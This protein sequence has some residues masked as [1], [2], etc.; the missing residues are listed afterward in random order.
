MRQRII[1][2][3]LAVVSASI[4]VFSVKEFIRINP[5]RGIDALAY[6]FTPYI[7]GAITFSIVYVGV[8]DWIDSRKQDK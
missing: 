6:G 7:F 2:F 3:I 4:T 8:I 5:T 1:M